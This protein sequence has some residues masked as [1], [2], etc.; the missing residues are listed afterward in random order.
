MPAPAGRDAKSPC[1]IHNAKSGCVLQ[2]KTPSLCLSPQGERGRLNIRRGEFWRPFSPRGEGQDEGGLVKHS[3]GFGIMAKAYA[4]AKVP[5]AMKAI[6]KHDDGTGPDFAICAQPQ[7][8]PASGPRL[9]SPL[10]RARRRIDRRHSPIAAAASSTR[11]TRLDRKRP[12]TPAPPDHAGMSTGLSGSART[13]LL[14]PCARRRSS[15]HANM[16]STI[17]ASGI[18]IAP[19]T[20]LSPAGSTPRARANGRAWCCRRGR[21]TAPPRSRTSP[22]RN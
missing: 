1:F 11:V 13:S 14:S 10:H 2:P 7:W 18:Q 15:Q 22:C 21:A 8:A 9:F 16:I 19:R 6:G 17:G 4:S 5:A 12:P 20:S 3:P